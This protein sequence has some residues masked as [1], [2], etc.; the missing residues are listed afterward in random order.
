M[1]GEYVA[2][3]GDCTSYYVCTHGYYV[4]QFCGSGLAWNDEKK[5][6]DWKYNVYCRYKRSSSV[7][8][9]TSEYYSRIAHTVR[10]KTDTQLGILRQST[11]DCVTDL[12]VKSKVECQEGE[13]ASHPKDC[14][15]YLQCLWGKFTVNSCPAGLYWNNVRIL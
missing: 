6:C 1:E 3:V 14:N 11:P 15:K 7:F 12:Y 13:F 9:Y 5:M 10:C 2:A 4:R 8:T